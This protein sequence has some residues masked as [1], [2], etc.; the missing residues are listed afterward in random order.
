M[1]LC[2]V[3]E[4]RKAKAGLAQCNGLC[5]RLGYR[6]LKRRKTYLYRGLTGLPFHL[7]AGP[8]CLEREDQGI[9]QRS[10]AGYKGNWE[11]KTQT[12]FMWNF[13]ILTARSQNSENYFSFL[14][15]V[16]HL[17]PKGLSDFLWWALRLPCPYVL[18]GWSRPCNRA[19]N[20]FIS[21]G[22]FLWGSEW[23]NSC[24][25]LFKPPPQFFWLHPEQLQE[26]I[27]TYRDAE[28]RIP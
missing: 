22:K 23:Q 24:L 20:S 14:S 5:T 16:H 10:T 17:F 21:G 13:K 6:K 8:L 12:T 1:I 3:L 15:C 2:S 4:N 18:A 11:Y 26:Y 7:L 25:T 9:S 19:G 27:Y 28:N